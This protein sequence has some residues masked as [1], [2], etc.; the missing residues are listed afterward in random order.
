MI[1]FDTFS[2]LQ[3][4]TSGVFSNFPNLRPITAMSTET[5]TLSYA[6]NFSRFS[7]VEFL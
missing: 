4:H 7:S 6:Y 2:A 3:L 5:A 1:I